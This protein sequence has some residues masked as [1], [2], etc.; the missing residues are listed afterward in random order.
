MD[1][2]DFLRIFRAK[3]PTRKV[4]IKT[5]IRLGVKEKFFKPKMTA[6]IV[7][8]I[9][10]AKEKLNASRGDKPTKRPLIIVVPDRETPG[11]RAI[12]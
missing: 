7:A 11:S 12:H 9:N 2:N 10:K 3:R 5:G 8:G 1:S 6:P 4:K